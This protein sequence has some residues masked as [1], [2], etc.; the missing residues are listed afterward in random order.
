MDTVVTPMTKY[1]DVIAYIENQRDQGLLASGD[2][3]PSLRAMARQL[4]MGLN[5]VIRAYQELEAEG[6][7]S[8]RDRSGYVLLEKRAEMP[9]SPVQPEYVDVITLARDV[10]AQA[11]D[12]NLLPLG[13]AHPCAD[14]PALK[15]LYSEISK[16]AREQISQPS[17]YQLPPGLGELRKH[18]GRLSLQ[19]DAYLPPDEVQITQG[20]Q[21]AISISLQVVTK[22]GDIILVNAPCYFGTLLSLE[23]LGLRVIEIPVDPVTGMDIQALKE[24][25][26][27]WPVK[28]LLLNPTVNNPAGY[29][30]P[31]ENRRAILA[32]TGD[33]P[34]IEDDCA[35]LLSQSRMPSALKALDRDGRVIYCASLSKILDSR[36][37]IGWVAAGRYHEQVANK[38]LLAGLGG[39]SLIQLGVARFLATGQFRRHQEKAKRAYQQRAQLARRQLTAIAGWQGHFS[40][41]EGGYLLWITLPPGTDGN[42]IYR[43]ALAEGISITPGSIFSTGG[44]FRN[45]IRLNIAHFEDNQRW[46]A[47]LDQ[48]GEITVR[49]LPN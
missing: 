44:Q 48:L 12:P 18:L 43:A 3:L 35:A 26:N 9:T 27:Q 33:L 39:V 4:D 30:L 42:Q 5:T 45:C 22:P 15:R 29:S 1:Q 28:A 24:A 23:A 32:A 49:H 46:R 16:A 17:G 8:A 20:A 7:V 11:Q 34:I 37:R 13:S 47:G 2:K 31:E 19:E 38:L 41:I 36:I 40:R 25:L 14:F 10:M 6:L 21:Q